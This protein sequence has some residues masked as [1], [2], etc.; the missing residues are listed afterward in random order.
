[1]KQRRKRREDKA[2]PDLTPM[3]DVTFQLLIFFILCARFKQPERNQQA[4]MPLN[5]GPQSEPEIPKEALTIHCQWDPDARAGEYVTAL[6]ARGRK[7]VVGARATLE[8]LVIFP[9]DSMESLRAKKALYA[10]VRQALI[11]D[12]EGRLQ[13]GQIEKFEIS[14]ARDPVRGAAS[15]TAPWMFTALA[16]DATA[17]INRDRMKRD[18]PQLPVTFKFTDALRQFAVR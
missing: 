4:D 14:T 9:G 15:G 1:M 16:I 17:K 7:A 6:G 10:E 2:V 5:E 3:I 11:Q 12:L 18:E 8:Q 13:R